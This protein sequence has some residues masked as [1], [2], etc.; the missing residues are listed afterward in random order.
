MSTEREK[1]LKLKVDLEQLGP[2]VNALEREALELRAEVGPAEHEALK[3]EIAG[4]SRAAD[5]RAAVRK[6]LERIQVISAEAV[7]GRKRIR[8]QQE[9]LGE[10]RD[11]ARVEVLAECNK[12]LA[13]TV[14]TFAEKFR[15]AAAAEIVLDGAQKELRNAFIEIDAPVPAQL[16]PAVPNLMRDRSYK[17]IKKS[18]EELLDRLASLGFDVD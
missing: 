8:A 17:D 6:A 16:E 12:R 18:W 15:A 10:F 2:K 5:R 3:F 1:Y 7:E 14:K 11:R 13:P 9:C 4:D